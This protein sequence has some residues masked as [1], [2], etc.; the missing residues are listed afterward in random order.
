VNPRVGRS[1][2]CFAKAVRREMTVA[3]LGRRM[4]SPSRRKI[5]SALLLSALTLPKGMTSLLGNVT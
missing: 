2:Y 5:K 4:S 3:S 1:L